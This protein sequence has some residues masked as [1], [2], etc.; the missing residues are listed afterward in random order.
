MF[1][2]LKYL[3]QLILSPSNGW[4]DIRTANPDPAQLQKKGLYPLIALAA[5][6]EF[7]VFF[8]NKD[9]S[10]AGVI[11][12]ALVD[13]GAYFI[14]LYVAGLILD[15]YLPRMFEQ[16]DSAGNGNRQALLIVF[17]IG[18]MVLIQIVANCLQANLTFMKFVPLYVVLI[19][20]KAARFMNIK[21]SYDLR[22]MCVA[23]VALVVVPALLCFLIGLIFA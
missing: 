6:T 18:L 4:E 20:Y 13:F 15:I 22:F 5:L 9:V 21:S 3:V 19:I 1:D 16:S 12:R 14:S 17:S 11:I 2:Y 7:C 23:S 10:V 8:Y